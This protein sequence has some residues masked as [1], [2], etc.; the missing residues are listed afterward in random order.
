MSTPLR[1][2][3]GRIVEISRDFSPEEAVNCDKHAR[4]YLERA[5]RL[6]DDMRKAFED[7]KSWYRIHCKTEQTK[8]C[9]SDLLCDKDFFIKGEID[10]Y[11]L[12]IPTGLIGAL[13]RFGCRLYQ[14]D[15]GFDIY[16]SE[17]EHV[18]TKVESIIEDFCSIR[19][20]RELRLLQMALN[21]FAS[22]VCE[23]IRLHEKE[24]RPT[25]GEKDEFVYNTASLLPFQA[26][27]AAF[28]IRVLED[29]TERQLKEGNILA[30]AAEV[31][32]YRRSNRECKASEK[33]INGGKSGPRGKQLTPVQKA[34]IYVYLNNEE[35]CVSKDLLAKT[36]ITH[37]WI[38]A[39]KGAYE[40]GHESSLI[41]A[42]ER[43]RADD[44]DEDILEIVREYGPDKLK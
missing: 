29:D 19:Q 1:M 9:I 44:F 13:Y 35:S 32:G 24:I 36:I 14:V 18:R 7:R 17:F 30:S 34:Q 40:C 39:G 26:A 38:K 10:Y 41:K 25:L 4:Y 11:P 22:Q 5:S 20:C 15:Y 3:N 8:P 33:E 27:K 21:L 2:S 6:A 42:A 43:H 16:L 23:A 28:A 31:R 12:C 37:N